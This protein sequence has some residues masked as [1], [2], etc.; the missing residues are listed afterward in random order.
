[1]LVYLFIERCEY[2]DIDYNS[3]ST[4]I[5]KQSMIPQFEFLKCNIQEDYLGKLEIDI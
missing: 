3:N 2:F 1:M 5:R 4:L